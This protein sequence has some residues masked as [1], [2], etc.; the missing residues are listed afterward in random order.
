MGKKKSCV[1]LMTDWGIDDGAVGAVHAV[2]IGIN[3]EANIVDMSHNV[4]SW[5]IKEAA[6]LLMAHY[7]FFPKGTIFVAVI[8]PG[9]G[10]QRKAVLVE[11]AF[12]YF[13]GPDNGVLSWALRKE[14]IKRVIN[15]TNDRFFHKPVSAAFQGRDV[16]C[17]VA[18][19]LS[20]GVPI[21]T[22]GEEIKPRHVA[23]FISKPDIVWTPYPLKK[24]KNQ[25]IGEV[26]FVDKF[27]NLITSIEEKEFEAFR[28]ETQYQIKVGATVI[29]KLSHTYN[30]G[31]ET[32]E[33]LAVFG[34]DFGDLLDIAVYESSAAEKLGVKVG[35]KIIVERL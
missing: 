9:V 6:F 10:T 26:L 22:F 12:Y 3:P 27:G 24:E 31:K 25:L 14:T 30:D 32:G 21:T 29:E 34:G 2:I 15:L 35:D 7:K 23:S 28:S 13:V 19:W 11:T 5:D 33:A 8:D 18:A 17:P 4:N 20:T 16:F 1:A